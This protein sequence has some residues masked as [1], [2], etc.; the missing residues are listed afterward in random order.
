LKSKAV[1]EFKKKKAYGL[2]R[3]IENYFNQVLSSSNLFIEK[4]Y[5]GYTMGGNEKTKKHV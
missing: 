5:D 4:S 3:D 2:T 1:N